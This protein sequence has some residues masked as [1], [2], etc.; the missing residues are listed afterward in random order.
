[1][2]KEHNQQHNE[3]H[4][5]NTNTTNDSSYNGYTNKETW[6]VNLWMNNDETSAS[7]M[8]D[9]ARVAIEDNGATSEDSYWFMQAV[10]DMAQQ[11]QQY[12]EEMP[13]ESV[14]LMSD[15]LRCAVG[16]VNWREIASVWI[17]DEL[18]EMDGERV[19]ISDEERANGPK[20]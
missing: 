1:M 11:L 19:T 10:K 6:L 5:M 2:S 15:L 8:R 14:G 20:I 16:S 3:E 13:S 18:L 4:T 9:W 17:T 12:V 7:M